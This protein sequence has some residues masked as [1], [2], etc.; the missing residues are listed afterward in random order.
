MARAPCI[1][2]AFPESRANKQ[3]VLCQKGMVWQFVQ[4]FVQTG[5]AER[6]EYC[7]PL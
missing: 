6:A 5:Q 1:Q 3:G 2:R 7:S 4:Q